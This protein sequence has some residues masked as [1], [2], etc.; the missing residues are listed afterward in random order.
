MKCVTWQLGLLMQTHRRGMESLGK[1][2]Q[3]YV[4]IHSDR[5]YPDLLRAAKVMR[6][7]PE[8]TITVRGYDHSLC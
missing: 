1:S 8:I 3:C 4:S 7:R 5:S 6:K 2:G